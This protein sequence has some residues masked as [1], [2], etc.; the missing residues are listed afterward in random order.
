MPKINSIMSTE[1]ALDTVKASSSLK[2]LTSVVKTFNDGW[3][4]TVSALH[5]AGDDFGAASAKV[6]GLTKVIAAQ[7]DKIEAIKAK[8]QDLGTVTSDT[9]EKFMALQ[10]RID[11]LKAKQNSLDDVTG[12]NK[13]AYDELGN[14][15]KDLQ[16]QQHDL[17]GVTTQTAQAYLRYQQEIDRSTIQL[18]RY[19]A[20]QSDARDV[21][22]RYE[23]GI[24]SLNRAMTDNDNL[25]SAQADKYRA[26]GDEYDALG[27]DAERLKD[28]IASLQAIQN[29]EKDIL[30]EVKER[31]GEDSEAYTKQATVV[32][33]LGAKIG[34]LRTKL[35]DTLK[36]Q[37]D[38]KISLERSKLGINELNDSIRKSDDLYQTQEERLKANG[39]DYEALSLKAHHTA[40][41]I[42]D[43]SEVLAKEKEVLATIKDDTGVDS[44]EYQRQAMV[45]E[46]LRTKIADLNKSY[47]ETAHSMRNFG[48]DNH[49]FSKVGESLDKLD[50]KARDTGHIFGKVLGAHLV[51]DGISNALQN[52][53]FHM[54]DLISK[55][56]Q[57]DIE[58]QKMQASWNT[59]AGSAKK[60]NQLVNSVNQLAI[61]T[62]QATD[63][64]NELEQGFYHL[65]SSK[66][67]ADAMTSAMLNMGDAV[68]LTGDQLE[69][70][71]HDMVDSLSRG[72]LTE[73]G[74]N[75]ISQYFPMFRDELAKTL[76]QINH[77]KKVTTQDLAQMTK[78]GQISAQVV[79]K[80]FENLGNGK[81]KDAVNNM[82]STAWGSFRTISSMIPRLFGSSMQQIENMRNPILLAV[83][84]WST[85]PQTMKKFQELGTNIGRQ[86]NHIISAFGGKKINVTK[87]L[88]HAID[89]INRSVTKLGHSI[90]SHRAVIK[91]FVSA[92]RQV[93]SLSMKVFIQALRMMLPVLNQVLRLIGKNPKAFVNFAAAMMITTKATRLLS[94]AFKGLDVI[95]GAVSGLLMASKATKDLGTGTTVA[96][97][98]AGLLT[99]GWKGLNVALKANVIA[100][101]VQALV[102]LGIE[103]IHLYNTNKTFRRSVNNIVNDFRHIPETIGKVG[104]EIRNLWD[105]CWSHVGSFFSSIWHGI[106]STFNSCWSGV[107]N[108]I[109]S[110]LSFISSIWSN[111]WSNISSFFGG[112]WSGIKSTAS[113]SITSIHDKLNY[114]LNKISDMWTHIWNGM[115]SALR[116]VW[117]GIKSTI[118]SGIN[119]VIG[120]LNDMIGAVNNLWHFFTGKN[121]LGKLS[122]V[123]FANGGT[124][125]DNQM[126]MVNDGGGSDYKELIQT[127]DDQFLMADERNQ[128]LPLPVGSRVYNGQETRQIMNMFGIPH[129]AKGGVVG[130]LNFAGHE[131][132]DFGK[133]IK[134][135][136]DSIVKFLK[137]PL[138]SIESFL[139]GVESKVLG[140]THI[141]SFVN[142]IIGLLNKIAKPM[143]DWFKKGL[144]KLKQQHDASVGAGVTMNN[145]GAHTG[146]WAGDIRKIAD[147]MHVHVSDSDMQAL[148]HRIQKE[149]GGNQ[150]VRQQVWDVNMAN[151]DPAMGLFQYIPPTFAA[152]S[153]PGHT[154]I[155]SGDDQI[156]AVF[157]DSNWRS[158][159][160]MPGGWGPTGHRV[161]ANGGIATQA[162]IFGEAGPEMAIPMSRMKSTRAWQLLKVLV[163]YESGNST[164]SFNHDVGNDN[165]LINEIKELRKTVSALVKLNAQ[166]LSAIKAQGSFNPQHQYVQQ[167]LDQSMSNL[168]SF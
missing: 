21:L 157:N 49:I 36:A 76:T 137:H 56:N 104:A 8:Q 156:R 83:S 154:N 1:V 125:G 16:D 64:V 110:G 85:D 131:L 12:K 59:L 93:G 13:D 81:Y 116:H 65:H 17:E 46:K 130:F 100:L 158:D 102:F 162:S 142:L 98:G 80:T 72:K 53:G 155:L 148:L 115:H 129:Y 32:A 73:M 89:A 42:R 19:K 88:D 146:S 5:A 152:W 43:F 62:G 25:L 164:P 119:D 145:V 135:K 95:H 160:R 105:S 35:N 91:E 20:Q 48:E 77:G 103:L 138:K 3:K 120:G 34:D 45:V 37:E 79:E 114:W 84:K 112:I 168:Q 153:L 96:S 38:S 68:G 109:G 113:N 139:K 165:S 66:P 54:Q 40:E 147:E 26:N 10:D 166:Q 67:E 159:I 7:E 6:D 63:T 150:S 28:K 74:L 15:I 51:A 18:N 75:Q 70:V 163:D 94:A 60:G 4:S 111:T 118:R 61:K 71:S 30:A 141:P 101:V 57:F 122:Y 143:S 24:F 128:V 47:Q 9:A 41:Q 87:G 55:G 23:K 117:S 22:E 167:A 27:T 121:A 86:L 2:S 108:S 107:K 29:K 92:M 123:H 33:Q 97:R 39:D 124:V 140:H 127:P 90:V 11:S 14:Q 69:E 106:S 50:E 161:F 151:G 31:N 44:D 149:S 99:K 144:S 58:Q 126:V 78:K 133:W 136:W 132:S 134:D 52:V 82:M